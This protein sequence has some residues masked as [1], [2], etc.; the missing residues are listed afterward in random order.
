VR[1]YAEE[2]QKVKSVL[3]RRNVALWLYGRWL[4]LLWF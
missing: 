2:G 4:L 3:W 1:G